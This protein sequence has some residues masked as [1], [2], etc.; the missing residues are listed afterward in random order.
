MKKFIYSTLIMSFL[1]VLST[2]AATPVASIVLSDPFVSNNLT[3]YTVTDPGNEPYTVKTTKGGLQCIHIPS[4]KYGYFNANDATIPSNQNNLIFYI[5][6]FDEGTGNLNLQ[7]N[8]NDATN[9]KA[10]SIKKTGT[11]TW[12]TATVAITNASFRNAPKQCL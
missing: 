4:N 10:M 8:A 2:N 7:Y 3:H 5:T 6:Y 1:L 9:Y 11:N 12:I